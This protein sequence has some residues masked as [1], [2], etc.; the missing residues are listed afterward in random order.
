MGVLFVVYTRKS[1]L[2]FCLFVCQVSN[3]AKGRSYPDF[4]PASRLRFGWVTS[5][6]SLFSVTKSVTRHICLIS[7]KNV[8]L[9]HTIFFLTC[10]VICHILPEKRYILA[11]PVQNLFERQEMWRFGWD[12]NMFFSFRLRFVTYLGSMKRE[13]HWAKTDPKSKSWGAKVECAFGG[14]F[15]RFGPTKRGKISNCVRTCTQYVTS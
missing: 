7:G 9:S 13:G 5:H 6:L 10:D 2:S 14:I 12:W 4:F 15:L 11:P 3:S 1:A 8:T